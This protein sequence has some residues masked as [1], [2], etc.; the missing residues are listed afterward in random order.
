MTGEVFLHG[1]GQ[2]Y[3]LPIPLAIYLFAAAGVVVLS[4]VMVVLLAGE[5]LG[6]EAVAHPRRPL[7]GLE[8]AT[9]SAIPRLAGGL[10]GVTGLLAVI[11]TAILGRQD[12][13]RNPAEYLV[14]VYFWAGAVILS[15]AIGNLW[16]LINPFAAI[17]DGIAR[18]VRLPAPRLLPAGVGIWPAI[19]TYFLFAC[20][21]L[22]SGVASR[23]AILGWIAV[24]YTLVT[25][26]GMVI[27]GRDEYLT[28]A[29]G[30]TV[31][32]DVVARF[33]P[34]EVE[35]DGT[36]RRRLWLRPPG[37]GLLRD[38][39]PGWDRVLFIVLMLSTLA[40]DGIL[41]TPVFRSYQAAAAPALAGAG[42]LALPILKTVGLALLTLVFL[43]AFVLVVRFVLWFGS[44]QA[45]SPFSRS[46]GVA[47]AQAMSAFALTLV[48]I[49]LVYNAAHNYTYVV[50]Q[51]QGLVPLL[52]DPFGLGWRL[53]P[54]A[55]YRPSFALAGAAV[56][57][58]VQVVLIVVGHVI[59]VYL[60]H[61][62]AGE[63]FKSASRV[64]LSQYPM[65]LLMVVYTMTSLWI[66][67]QPITRE[68]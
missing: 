41:A 53:L 65:L 59:A 36:G 26:A 8:A 17:H 33:A 3:D 12:P 46:A 66:L 45:A 52:A 7:L 38:D 63:R 14:F 68:G 23:P 29:E 24:F 43:A 21:E 61:L 15:G 51:S 25:L 27:F 58:Y 37:A 1:F 5:R 44:P 50:L 62:R 10:V 49:A 54:T 56:V 67:A 64:L 34:I 6:A 2:R 28:R 22:T 40:F 48:P 19:A 16:S 9:N 35:T 42:G 55:G 60:A 13:F 30:F 18:L 57:W 20:L 11:A 32:F 39:R 4:F 47:S 31:L